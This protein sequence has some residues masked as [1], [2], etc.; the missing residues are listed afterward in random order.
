MLI[1]NAIVKMPWD[2]EGFYE[3]KNDG[4]IAAVNLYDVNDDKIAVMFKGGKAFMIFDS[5]L[6]KPASRDE[7]QKALKEVVKSDGPDA[8]MEEWFPDDYIEL[9]T[10]ATVNSDVAEMYGFTEEQCEDILNRLADL[11]GY[12]ETTFEDMA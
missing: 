12:V 3:T 9:S 6:E 7:L 11:S 2:A 10:G 8:E 1:K 5:E 4:F